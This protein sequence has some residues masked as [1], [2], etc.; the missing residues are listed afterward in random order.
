[1]NHWFDGLAMLHRFGI[2]DGSV[3][4][5]SRFLET[6]AYR[7]A[8]DTGEI[9]LLGVR[10]RPVPDALPARERDVLAEALRQ[11]ERQPDQARRALHLDDRDP[12]AGPVRRR[13][14]RNGRR[15]LRGPRDADHRTPAPR[16]R[17]QGD[18]QLRGR[19]RAAQRVPLLPSR[20]RR[21]RAGGDRQQRGSA[22]PRTCTRSGSASAGS[23]WPSSRSWSTRCGWPPAAARTSRTTAGSPS[24]APA[25]R[26][27]IAPRARREGRSTT[28][29]CFGFHHVNAYEDGDEVVV[30]ICVFDDPQIVE[31]LYLERLRAGKPVARPEL[32]RFR[33]NPRRRHRRLRA[34]QRRGDRAA[35][36][37]LRPLQRA[38]LPLRLGRRGGRVRVAGGHR[39]GRRLE[40]RETTVWSEPGLL[41]GRAGVRR[42]ARGPRRRTTGSCSRSCSTPSAGARSSLV[43][44]AASLEELARAEAPHHIPFGFHGQ[45]ARV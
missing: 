37:Q 30:D 4:Y 44:D 21:R 17:Q 3:S 10:H 27:S 32:R 28:D 43:L 8:R 6:R 1:M 42:R 23:C 29:A 18:A 24:S 25:S 31:D 38:A 13:D 22:S 16:P 40:T 19:P 34:P 2:G 36:D 39:Q 35:A 7:A 45:F 26:S 41:R 15:R 20:A 11:R 14:A 9:K 33:I 5:A 12:D